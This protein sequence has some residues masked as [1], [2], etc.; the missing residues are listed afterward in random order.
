VPSEKSTGWQGP[1]ARR[2]GM[3]I[4]EHIKKEHK[5][6]DGMLQKLSRGYDAAVFDELKL[7]LAAHM[8]AEEASLYPAMKEQEADM[9]EHANEE[10]AEIRDILGELD[11]GD[12][13]GNPFT[14]KISKLTEVINDH[15]MDEEEDM[16]PKA[17]EMFDQDDVK[18][19]SEK[20]DEVDER[21]MQK[22]K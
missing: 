8:K 1:L 9:V 6:V 12:K 16:F 17:K 13:K 18:K 5:E 2:D 20:F 21:I 7:A 11:E 10:H 3:D 19:L 4:F 15:V 22:T 14:S